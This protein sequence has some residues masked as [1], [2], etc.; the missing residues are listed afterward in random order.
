MAR[1]VQI[2]Y[3][4]AVLEE[5]S[6]DE[7]EV[8]LFGRGIADMGAIGGLDQLEDLHE[9]YLNDNQISEIRGLDHLVSLEYL[10]L[11]DNQIT[12]ISGLDKLMNLQYLGLNGNCIKEIKGLDALVNLDV[13]DLDY[14][15][16]SEIKGLERLEKLKELCLGSG[17]PIPAILI[18]GLGGL[19]PTGDDVGLVADPSAFVAYCKRNVARKTGRMCSFCGKMGLSPRAM[20]CPRCGDPLSP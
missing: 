18:K 12:E 20:T 11:S 3:R 6:D 15:E 9:I 7:M 10:H 17:N 8:S 5:V 13:L 19:V 4:G 16:I 2:T 14:N 1:T